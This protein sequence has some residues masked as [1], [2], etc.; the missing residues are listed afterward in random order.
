MS[1]NEALQ[2]GLEPGVHTAYLANASFQQIE[3][4][5]MS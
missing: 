1:T 4:N 5:Q 2:G 3:T